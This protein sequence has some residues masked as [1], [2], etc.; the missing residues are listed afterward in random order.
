MMMMF[1]YH[2]GIGQD[3][4]KE[5]AYRGWNGVREWGFIWKAKDGTAATVATL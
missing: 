5:D 1:A 3:D 2:R 4:G